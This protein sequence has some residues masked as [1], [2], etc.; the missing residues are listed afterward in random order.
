MHHRPLSL[1]CTPAHHLAPHSQRGLAK[2]SKEGTGG[3]GLDSSGFSSILIPGSAGSLTLTAHREKP[4]PALPTLGPQE[5]WRLLNVSPS[6]IQ[7]P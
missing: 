5:V 4:L 2:W 6:P 1:H 3:G 7:V